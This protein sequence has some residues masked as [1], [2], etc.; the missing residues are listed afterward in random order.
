MALSTV[1]HSRELKRKPVTNY[2]YTCTCTY[3]YTYT[4]T[5]TCTCSPYTCTCTYLLT[6]WRGQIGYR[7]TDASTNLGT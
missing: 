6:R 7:G 5:C 4:C 1:T 2:T 3:T